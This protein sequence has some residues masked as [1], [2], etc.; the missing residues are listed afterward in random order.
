ML[1]SVI[2]MHRFQLNDA[3]ET[4]RTEMQPSRSEIPD[5]RSKIRDPHAPHPKTKRSETQIQSQKPHEWRVQVEPG[6][7][8]S[9]RVGPKW[10]NVHG[11][12]NKINFNNKKK[13]Q[14]VNKTII[15]DIYRLFL[16]MFLVNY[17]MIRLIF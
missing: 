16:K 1:K 12:K 10:C 2:Y 9:G 14:A 4:G 17:D 15:I 6:A 3:T 11:T 5:P 7:K 13:R 8:E